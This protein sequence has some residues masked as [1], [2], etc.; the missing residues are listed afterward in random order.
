MYASRVIEE[1][2]WGITKK[3]IAKKEF[4][5]IPFLLKESHMFKNLKLK[6]LGYHLL[7]QTAF[8][9][10]NIYVFSVISRT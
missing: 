8:T 3:E 4:K 2:Q 1:V 7:I 5:M 9:N 10:F 6:T